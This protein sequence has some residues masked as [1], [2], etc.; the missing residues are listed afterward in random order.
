MLIKRLLH[1]AEGTVRIRVEAP[2][3]ER[4]FNLLSSNAIAFWDVKRVSPTAFSCTLARKDYRR[5]RQMGE[6]L[7]CEIRVERRQGAPYLAKEF[8][9]RLTLTLSL[10]AAVAVLALGSFCVWDFEIEGETPVSDEEIL[11]ALQKYG[12]G[13]GTFSGDIDGEELRN[14]ILLDLPELSWI[15]VNVRGFRAYVQ[16]RPRTP[17]PEIVD[18]K[19]PVNIVARRSGV[20]QKVEA[21]GGEAVV[22]PGSTVSEGDLLISGASHRGGR[23]VELLAAMGKVE[24]RTWH[25][26]SASLPLSVREKE[27]KEEKTSF[28]LLVGTKRIKIFGT[29]RYEG[30]EYAKITDRMKW[31]LFGLLP[32]PVYTV[33][34]RIRLYETVERER[35]TADTKAVGEKLLQDYLAT[36]LPEDGKVLATLCTAEERNGRLLVTLRAECLESIGKAVEIPQA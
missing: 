26:L 25:T 28:S 15:A 19:T 24:A 9:R 27:I 34:E 1:L 35:S 12:V 30:E 17:K 7:A 4:M 8:R 31:D 32:L 21:L 33:K 6:S 29:S 23:E 10:A 13:I 18:E 36:L 3:P 16:V 14:H 20:I 11:R 5:L 22:L 2:F